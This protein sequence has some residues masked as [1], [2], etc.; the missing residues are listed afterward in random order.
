ML[1]TATYFA[2]WTVFYNAFAHVP[3]RHIPGTVFRVCKRSVL[4]TND[5]FW[6]MFIVPVFFGN[7]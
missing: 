6:R 5:A 3:K 1:H 7:E 2:Y 4:V